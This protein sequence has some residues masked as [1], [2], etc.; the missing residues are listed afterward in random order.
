VRP[1]RIL[2][3]GGASGSGKSSVAHV[4][5]RRW[6]ANVLCADDVRV[7][8]EAAAEGATI[9]VFHRGRDVPL[10]AARLPASIAAWQHV[11][12]LVSRAL[13]RVILLRMA[14]GG[15]FVL[16]G[17][18]LAPTLV[19]ASAMRQLCAHGVLRMVVLTTRGPDH[20]KAQLR[21]RDRGF[22]QQHQT[23]QDRYVAK[24]WGCAVWLAAHAQVSGVPVVTVCAS[25]ALTAARVLAVTRTPRPGRT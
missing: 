21:L 24:H 16:E 9:G 18:C 8:M 14:Y 17:D 5:A 7:A 20:L 13:Q 22:L 10:D 15:R 2:L 11:S 19:Q 12:D 23:V 4:V 6:N 1:C 25:P 3:L